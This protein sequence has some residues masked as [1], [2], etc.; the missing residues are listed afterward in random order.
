MFI[1]VYGSDNCER[2]KVYLPALDEA[3]IEFVFIDAEDEK[4]D[5]LCEEYDIDELPVTQI[6][7][8]DGR[9]LGELIGPLQPDFLIEWIKE[10]F[11]KLK[12]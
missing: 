7:E 12:K 3:K 9:I 6:V 5:D 10:I 2:C 11:A 8:D 4:N 1:R